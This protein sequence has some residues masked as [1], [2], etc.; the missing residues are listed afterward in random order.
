MFIFGRL[1]VC[2]EKGFTLFTVLHQNDVICSR[3]FPNVKQQRPSEVKRLTVTLTI[4]QRRA[5]EA[6]ARHNHATLAFVVR[7][8]LAEFID[9]HHDGQ[10]TLLFPKPRE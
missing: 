8:A 4:E 3:G 5:L 6:I 10:L 9:R 2:F 1:E 7:Y